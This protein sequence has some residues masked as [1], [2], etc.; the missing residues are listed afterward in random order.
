MRGL[1]MDITRERRSRLRR[2][3][4]GRECS[5]CHKY[6]A[7]SEFYRHSNGKPRAACKACTIKADAA[8]QRA[9]KQQEQ[10]QEALQ[11]V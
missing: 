9:A 8:Y 1:Y 6:K 4:D 3:D 5:Q 2:D 7:Y 11:G 10:A